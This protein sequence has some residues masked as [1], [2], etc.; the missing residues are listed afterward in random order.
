LGCICKRIEWDSWQCECQ[1]MLPLKT[2]F[3]CAS[4]IISDECGLLVNLFVWSLDMP[5][6]ALTSPTSDGHSVGQY[7]SLADWNHRGFFFCWSLL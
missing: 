4:S 6:L 7:S 2:Y 3:V 1:E 5:T